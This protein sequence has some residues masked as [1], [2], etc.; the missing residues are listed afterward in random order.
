MKKLVID[1]SVIIKWLNQED[2]AFVEEAEAILGDL[3]SEKVTLLAPELTKYEIGNALL[4]G[5]K[6]TLNQIKEALEFLYDLPI[7][8]VADSQELSIST[9]KIGHK[10][11]LTYYDASFVALA[12]KENATLVT[13]NPKHQA[14]TTEISSIALK[15]YR[16]I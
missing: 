16:K 9:Y 2:E 11:H 6:L 5:K 3:R 14:K 13:D 10:S 12:K 4:V 15:Y 1:S 8:F 7:Q